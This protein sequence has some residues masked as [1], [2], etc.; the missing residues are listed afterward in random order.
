MSPET[1]AKV[2][3]LVAQ[4]STAVTNARARARLRGESDALV[5][6]NER[7]DEASSLLAS[8]D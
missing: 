8:V 1:A 5:I 3:E 6:A 4:A 2:Q 7:L